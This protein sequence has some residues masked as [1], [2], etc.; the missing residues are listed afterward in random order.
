MKHS[1][2]LCLLI[3]CVLALASLLTG[4]EMHLPVQS[5][6]EANYD[7]MPKSI[8]MIYPQGL[9]TESYGATFDESLRQYVTNCGI[10]YDSDYKTKVSDTLKVP[11]LNDA[12]V[13]MAT[14]SKYDWALEITVSK[15]HYEQAT[16]Y[17]APIGIPSHTGVT[18]NY[19]L[20]DM[21]GERKVWRA[22]IFT[23]L[24]TGWFGKEPDFGKR[25][26]QALIKAMRADG[27]LSSCPDLSP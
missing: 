16:Y 4:C 11:N 20:M 18:N 9:R 19:T 12:K 2:E 23:D 25:A 27:L 5:A 14:A 10:T 21:A 15:D 6:K 8:F 13:T 17:G 22:N 24:K 26:A 3:V 7:R 1:N